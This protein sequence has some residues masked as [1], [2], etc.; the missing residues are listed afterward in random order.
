M[1]NAVKVYNPLLPPARGDAQA[2]RRSKEPHLGLQEPVAL[3]HLCQGD[4]LV[5]GMPIYVLCS[6]QALLKVRKSTL[7][8]QKLPMKLTEPALLE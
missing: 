1:G 5:T 8:S 4:E 3:F 7:W 6:F 2:V